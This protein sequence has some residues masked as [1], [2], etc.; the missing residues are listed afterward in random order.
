MRR[1]GLLAILAV[2]AT[3]RSVAMQQCAY[4]ARDSTPQLLLDTLPHPVG[5]V[6]EAVS[7]ALLRRGYRIAELTDSTVAATS[8]ADWP[9]LPIPLDAHLLAHQHPGVV[10]RAAWLGVGDSTWLDIIVQ[11]VCGVPPEDLEHPH[12]SIEAVARTA[13]LFD[14]QGALLDELR[15]R[16]NPPPAT[17]GF[18]R[19]RLESCPR[20]PTPDGTGVYPGDFVLLQVFI[21]PTGRVEPGTMTVVSASGGPNTVNLARSIAPRCRFLPAT[22]DGVPVRARVRL[23]V[24][25]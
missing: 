7:A 11:T 10:L 3:G 5:A 17:N 13:A 15:A 20:P 6:R 1:L 16:P 18:E 12:A 21:D 8:R 9:T 23:P 19:P 14:L 25:F 2:T 4:P 22:I 24:R